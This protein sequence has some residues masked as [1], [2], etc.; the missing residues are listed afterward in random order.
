MKRYAVLLVLLA[1][2]GLGPLRGT[3]A[4]EARQ[5]PTTAP[6]GA[7]AQCPVSGATTAPAAGRPMSSAMAEMLGLTPPAGAGATTGPAA[8]GASISIQAVQGT[9]DGPKITGGKATI[10]LYRGEGIEPEV[11]DAN[12]D[13]NGMALLENLSLARPFQPVVT[14]EHAGASYEAVGEPITPDQP[15]QKID[16]DVYETTDKRP[17]LKV[18]MR[19]VVAKATDEGLRVMD[20]LIVSNPADRTWTGAVGPDGKPAAMSVALPAGVKDIEMDGAF[21]SCCAV[22]KD[23]KL[24]S[25]APLLPGQSEFRIAYLVP[26]KGGKASMTIETPAPVEGMILM[27][28][29]DQA[30]F[31]NVEGLEKGE[32]YY[33][34]GNGTTMRTFMGQ[35]VMPGRKIT[36]TMTGLPEAAQADGFWSTPKIAGIVGGGVLLVICIVFLIAKPGR[37][38]GQ[39]EARA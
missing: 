18:K 29:E 39:A 13:G 19:H 38:P 2:G 7:A 4:A 5:G 31:A 9:K 12:L 3:V 10:R 21:H 33:A 11:M 24:V 25:S 8:S 14:I 30:G 34:K 1:A 16:V 22:L 26:G 17:D 28:P 37:K 36:L 35:D 32:A 23:G 20:V 15:T 27:V 6:A